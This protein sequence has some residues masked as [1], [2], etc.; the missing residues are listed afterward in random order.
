MTVKKAI[1]GVLALV[2]IVGFLMTCTT[3]DTSSAGKITI[4]G[5]NSYNNRLA[6]VGLLTSLDA[7]EEE[8]VVYGMGTI[9]KGTLRV[10]LLDVDTGMPWKNGG[11]Y[12]LML[13][14]GSTFGLEGSKAMLLYTNGEI[15]RFPE[16]SKQVPKYNL[17]TIST[18]RSK[19]HD[20]TN[21]PFFD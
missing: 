14:F 8:M 3:L 16:Q 4:A 7:S 18:N 13:F 12:N 20:V 6:G 19:F 2:L 17:A 9:S 11:S 10:D 15:F 5:L 1:M 21:N